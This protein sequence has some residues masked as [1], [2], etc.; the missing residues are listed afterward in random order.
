MISPRFKHQLRFWSRFASG[1]L[2]LSRRR[3]GRRYDFS[4]EELESVDYLCRVAAPFD[5]SEG[6]LLGDLPLSRDTSYMYD[7]YSVLK[8]SGAPQSFRFFHYFGDNTEDPPVPTFVK[9]R[10]IDA[11]N[12]GAVLLPLDTVRHFTFASDRRPFSE[13]KDMMVW[14]GALNVSHRL[15]FLQRT[16]HLDCCDVGDSGPRRGRGKARHAEF[17]KPRLSIR[18]QLRFKFVLSIEG[19]DVATNLKWIMSSNSVCVMPKPRYETWIMEGC[20]VP[21]LHYIEV[22]DDFSDLEDKFEFYRARPALCEE[23]S[24]NANR[25]IR[26][27][28]DLDRQYALAGK[29]VEKYRSFARP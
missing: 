28:F 18:E 6:V 21:G 14:R 9:S 19:V 27:F 11:P 15:T 29:V 10:P 13:K 12:A 1:G 26:R 2:G 24:A 17:E 25:Y 23:I 8:E 4:P 7:L 22:A 16:F 5:A 3:G 20:L